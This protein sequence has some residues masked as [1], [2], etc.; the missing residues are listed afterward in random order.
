MRKA[1][2]TLECGGPRSDEQDRG[3]IRNHMFYGVTMILSEFV[4]GLFY[5]IFFSSNA[6]WIWY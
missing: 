1:A 6:I 2:I 5:F 4:G 3:D